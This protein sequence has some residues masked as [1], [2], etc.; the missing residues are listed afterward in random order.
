MDCHSPDIRSGRSNSDKQSIPVLRQDEQEEFSEL[1]TALNLIDNTQHYKEL[2]LFNGPRR[3]D[4]SITPGEQV[5]QFNEAMAK[6]PSRR[7]ERDIYTEG[8]FTDLPKTRRISWDH[9]QKVHTADKEAFHKSQ[10]EDTD[11]EESQWEHRKQSKEFRDTGRIAMTG[12]G[13]EQDLTRTK[14][15]QAF[16][17]EQSRTVDK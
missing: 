12:E 11:G 4:P 5:R 6:L 17:Q 9:V 8:D 3:R 1:R 7:A 15:V 16:E 13:F 10:G 2:L 14:R